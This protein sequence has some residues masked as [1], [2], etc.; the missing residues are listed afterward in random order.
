ML[1]RKTATSFKGLAREI[2][3]GL[4]FQEAR[5]FLAVLVPSSGEVDYDDFVLFESGR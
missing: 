3:V 1:I 5:D 2:L 4:L